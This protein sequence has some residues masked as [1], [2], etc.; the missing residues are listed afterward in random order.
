MW[1]AGQAAG[2][3]HLE[4]GDVVAH[5][6][7]FLVAQ[8]VAVAEVAVIVYLDGRTQVDVLL[9]QPQRQ[10]T[11]AHRLGPSAGND[12]E[13]HAHLG[14]QMERIAVLDVD[15]TH[16]LA[17]RAHGNDVC[18]EHAVHIEQQSPYLL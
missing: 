3:H 13:Q 2:A 9:L 7:D 14:C 8:A 4:V 6:K 18:T 12:A 15:G 10:E 17:F 1:T 11:A 16:G 5:V